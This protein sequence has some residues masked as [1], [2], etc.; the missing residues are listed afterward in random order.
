[1]VTPVTPNARVPNSPE[2]RY[3]WD[4]RIDFGWDPVDF[5]S[6]IRSS[7][8]ITIKDFLKQVHDGRFFYTDPNN[9]IELKILTKDPI[10]DQKTKKTIATFNIREG[11]ALLTELNSIGKTVGK[12]AKNTPSLS[13]LV[14]DRIR[15]VPQPK[16]D[17]IGKDQK[18]IREI[19]VTYLNTIEDIFRAIKHTDP[20]IMERDKYD[21]ITFRYIDYDDSNT[22]KDLVIYQSTDP[23]NSSD[24]N[25]YDILGILIYSV[26]YFILERKDTSTDGL[27]QTELKAHRRGRNV[28]GTDSSVG[29]LPMETKTFLNSGISIWEKFNTDVYKGKGTRDQ[30]IEFYR[31]IF[32]AWSTYANEVMLNEQIDDAIKKG[33]SNARASEDGNR[34]WKKSIQRAESAMEEEER[35]L[36]SRSSDIVAQGNPGMSEDFIEKKAEIAYRTAQAAYL[37]DA[38]FKKWYEYTDIKWTRDPVYNDFM[39]KNIQ[40]LPDAYGNIDETDNSVKG[41]EI[42]FIQHLADMHYDPDTEAPKFGG[43]RKSHRLKRKTTRSRKSKKSKRTKRSRR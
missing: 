36:R 11:S 28:A 4:Y 40:D 26:G 35:K 25:L 30:F 6:Y 13:D 5:N 22:Q 15:I 17:I 12:P 23:S 10:I 24:S 29:G 18:K 32:P 34:E 37:S 39:K 31:K 3:R 8:K 41:K 20:N 19:T 21:S 16:C 33:E 7:P 42:M 27:S 2:R 9:K 1:M 38:P 14:K 43:I